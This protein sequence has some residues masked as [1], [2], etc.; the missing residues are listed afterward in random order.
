M[1]PEKLKEA[2]LRALMKQARSSSLNGGERGS[3]GGRPF[4]EV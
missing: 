1:D 3:D 2:A 4:L